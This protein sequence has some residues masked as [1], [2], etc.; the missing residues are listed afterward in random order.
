MYKTW[1]AWCNSFWHSFT[2]LHL[3]RR[4]VTASRAWHSF[5]IY[6]ALLIRPR[7]I[8]RRCQ[9]WAGQIEHNR[10]KQS[11]L[12]S[13][14]AETLRLFLAMVL[15]VFDNNSNLTDCESVY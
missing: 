10:D 8:H 15:D 7:L 6:Q 1:P 5:V 12:T 4:T 11:Y 2:I 14:L 9:Q 3:Q 13:T